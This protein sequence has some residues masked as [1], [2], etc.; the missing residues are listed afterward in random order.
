MNKGKKASRIA[1]ASSFYIKFVLKQ[2]ILLKNIYSK[3]ILKL[4]LLLT[5]LCSTINVHAQNKPAF[6]STTQNAFFTGDAFIENIGQYGTMY[7][8]QE[9]MGN[10]IFGF[11]GHSM[12][13]LFTKTGLIILQ[14]KVE[15]ISKREEEKLEKQG[16]SEEEIEHKKTVTDRAITLEWVGANTN[17]KIIQTEKTT[18]Y[19]TY[20][21]LTTKAFGYKKITYK[22]LYNGI[23]LVYH[24]T[25]N[26]KIGFEYSLVTQA[27]ADLSQIKMQYG[28]D[29][30]TI[31]INKQGNLIINS[32]IEGVEQSVPI[33][34]Y[35]DAVGNGQLAAGDLQNAISSNKSPN[36]QSQIPNSIVAKT[37]I[38]K[39][40][41]QLTNQPTNQ[42][43]TT[44]KLTNNH[45]SFTLPDG[46]DKTKP[47]TID[48]FISSTN[49]LD[50]LNAGKAK[51]I[52]YDYAGNVYVTGGG[53]VNTNHRLAKY[54]AA[55]ILQWTFNGVLTA[56]VW[57]F[58]IAFGGWVVEKPTGRIYLGQGVIGNGFKVVRLNSNGLY[59][60]YITT[61]NINFKENW[62]M[63][64]NCNA[65]TAQILIGGGGGSSNVNIA[66][67]TPSINT[68][69]LINLTGIAYTPP[70]VFNS[71][72]AQDIVDLII[73]PANF[74][75]YTI[76]AS[77]AGTP[78]LNNKIYKN[79]VPYSATS[80]SWN[81]L[82]GFTSLSEAK[83]RPYLIP[84]GDTTTSDNSA[85]ILTL[86]P[87]YLFYWDGKNLKAFNKATGAGVG[88]PLIT[89][90][91][92]KMTGGIYAD[93][94]N[95]VYVGTTSGTIKV[96]NFNGI[97]FDDAPAD[98]SI[99]GYSTK[100]VYDLAYNE[101]NKLLYA[102]GDGF[103]TSID[104][105]AT[106][107]NAGIALN[108]VPTCS[109]A[110]VAASLSPAAPAGSVVTYTLFNAATQIA[111]NTTGVFTSLQP[112]IN[113]T[114]SATINQ[115][116][117]GTQVVGNFTLPQSAMPIVPNSPITYCQAATANA[118]TATGTNLL[119]YSL[120][121]GGASTATAPT[122]STTVIGTTTYYVT[123]T[124]P[125]NCESIRV[126][127]TVNI[128]P[129]LFANAG[130]SI[131]IAQGASTQFN[132][133][134]TTGADYTWTANIAPLNLSNVKILNPIASPTQTT[135]Y[136][137]TVKDI[138]GYC[139]TVSSSVVINVIGT[140]NC[141]QVRNAFTPNGDT[142]NDLWFVY[143]QDFCLAKDAVAVQVYNR[144]GSKVY[145]NRNYKNTWDG[146]HNGKPLPDG[147]Y[148]AVIVFTLV[149]GTKQKVRSDVSIVR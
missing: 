105:T 12:P 19:H 130:P 37:E 137:L 31:K 87:T 100:S 15:K 124:L 110:S 41:N 125:N 63:I 114:I 84:I 2:T 128:V 47:I 95:N 3:E 46:Y 132:A 61:P 24:F 139:P 8:G 94:C 75:M 58:G 112:L 77:S 149:D 76:F 44:Y 5:V 28:G 38:N 6:T 122:P 120:P 121:L 134:A 33:S 4:L 57:Q 50:G 101:A 81:T 10:I 148:Y 115:A 36:S 45:I 113:Y 9:N 93:A 72:A 123:Q 70:V 7:K 103:V 18:A 17:V 30:K 11:E 16:L 119:W 111:T 88:T 97:V 136:L 32:D 65:S 126:P 129:A 141:I 143:D 53:N 106:C 21:L 78:I 83:N 146:T 25:P 82:S 107:F 138:Q 1:S 73:D 79:T 56:P 92:A 117:S 127:V 40:T 22:N 91:V 34:F 80:I 54:N 35:G 133:T 26:K 85:N 99:T 27:G 89:S 135:T 86:N 68:I 74:E 90:S 116:C 13:I 55:G 147:T 67:L 20:G 71:G 131:N 140:R 51:D 144:Y 39:S 42:L 109:T 49:N 60:N 43:I 108:I 96:Y 59:D 48:P 142:K 62:K 64:W 66:A 145:E 102:S 29:T 98:I 23:D 104:L 14:R 118:L 69:T 52:D